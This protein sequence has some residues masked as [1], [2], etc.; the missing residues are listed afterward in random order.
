[1]D[2]KNLNLQVSYNAKIDIEVTK[3][4]LE[5]SRGSS[6]QIFIE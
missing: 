3:S 5:S 6:R 2:A 1:M 4:S